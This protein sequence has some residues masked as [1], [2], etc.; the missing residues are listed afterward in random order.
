MLRKFF[1]LMIH[2]AFIYGCI[3]ILE[4]IPYDTSDN[5]EGKGLHELPKVGDNF[6]IVESKAI[7]YYAGNGKYEY[8]SVDCYFGYGNPSFNAKYEDGGLKIIDK[9]IADKIPL[10]GNMCDKQDNQLVSIVANSRNTLVKKATSTNYL[11]DHFSE[12]SHFMTYFVLSLSILYHRRNRRINYW[13]V[14]GMC[15]LGG[16]LLEFIQHFFIPGRS[17]SLDD[18]VL[19][20]L[21]AFFG[22]LFF[23]GFRNT[24]LGKAILQ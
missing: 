24:R 14:F 17:A 20:S 10:L 11:L 6:A 12:V 2:P 4:C 9:E 15:F 13:V 18:Q 1:N 19:N 16:T 7:F 23:L 22:I 3:F 21:G 5:K 8:T